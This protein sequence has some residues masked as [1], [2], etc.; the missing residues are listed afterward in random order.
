MN[1][2]NIFRS[3]VLLVAFG[4]S[5]CSSSSSPATPSNPTVAGTWVGT[6]QRFGRITLALNQSG[7]TV[8]GTWLTGNTSRAVGG[9]AVGTSVE[10]NLDNRP[11]TCVLDFLSLTGTLGGNVITGTLGDCRSSENVSLARQ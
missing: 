11:T 2:M 7:I 8:A 3:A 6:T 5:A 4:L 9:Q 10:L 1:S